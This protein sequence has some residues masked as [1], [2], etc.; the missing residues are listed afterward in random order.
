MHMYCMHVSTDRYMHIPSKD[1]IGVPASQGIPT[2]EVHTSDGPQQYCG[3]PSLVEASQGSS[4]Q[5]ERSPL[6]TVLGH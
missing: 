1:L 4:A 2:P 6:K 5:M 3:G